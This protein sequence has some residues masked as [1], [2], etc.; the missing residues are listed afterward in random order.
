LAAAKLILAAAKPAKPAKIYLGSRQ[1]CLPR[2]ILAAAKL[3]LAAA[4]L[5]PTQASLSKQGG[6][7]ANLEI[8]M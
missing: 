2:Y 5:I 6:M 7:P 4:K 8:Y 3:I 1:A